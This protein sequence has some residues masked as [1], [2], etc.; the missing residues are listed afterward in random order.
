MSDKETDSPDSNGSGHGS[1]LNFVASQEDLTNPEELL[2]AR[3]NLAAARASSAVTSIIEYKSSGQC[4]V[5]AAAADDASCEQAIDCAEQLKDLKVTLLCPLDN[6]DAEVGAGKQSTESGLKIFYRHLHSIQGYLGNFDVLVS[7]AI[8]PEE[9][10]QHLGVQALTDHGLFDLIVDLRQQ[11]QL[12]ATSV[13]QPGQ[14]QVSDAALPPFGY[15][16]ASD[17]AAMQHAIETLPQM[18]GEFEKPRYFSYDAS[19]CAHSR[20]QITGCNNCID[21]CATNAISSEG[22]SVSVN[23]YLCQGCGHC[24]TVCPSGA[25]T[26][27]FPSAAEAI[28]KTRELMDKRGTRPSVLLLHGIDD[29]L[30]DFDQMDESGDQ[31]SGALT[32]ADFEQSLP[33]HVLAV[34]VEEPSAYGIDYWATMIAAGIKQVVV[35]LEPVGASPKEGGDVAGLRS[36]TGDNALREQAG[37]LGQMLAGLGLPDDMVR[38]VDRHHN[39]EFTASL[40]PASLPQWPAASFATHN[41]KRQTLRMAMDHLHEHLQS[42]VEAAPLPGPSP[43]GR[44]V[45]KADACTLCMA[46]VTTCPAGALLDGHSLPQLKFVEANCVQC[47]LCRSACPESALDLEPR[48]LFNSLAARQQHI[49]N[50]EE[51]FHCVRCHKAFAT[52]KMIENM[53]GKLAGHWMFENESAV[54]RLKMCEDCR[55]KDMFEESNE[56]IQVH[57]TEDNKPV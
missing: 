32:L 29:E 5:I 25:M 24:A 3:Q 55:V 19:I 57:K 18:V 44:L 49:L 51:P 10:P 28:S 13:E 42:S 20:S 16:R 37:L 6:G 36:G 1:A 12:L 33:S 43:F 56:G 23:P 46:C 39:A 40:T 8:T 7:A 48:Y 35:L 54:R 14:P 4:L 15:F 30:Q 45:I 9:A 31:H 26:Y 41:D 21:V 38:V 50:E 27:A 52:Q 53:T 11:K 17:S 47:G 22:D 34:A 2:R